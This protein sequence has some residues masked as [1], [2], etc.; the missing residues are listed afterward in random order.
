MDR[1]TS[2]QGWCST[3][4]RSV[5]NLVSVPSR[6]LID[7]LLGCPCSGLMVVRKV[8]EVLSFSYMFLFFDGNEGSSPIKLYY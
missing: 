1:H 5:L 8:S 3:G 4:R 7:M 6:L 2:S